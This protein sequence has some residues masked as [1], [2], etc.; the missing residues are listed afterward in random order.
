[1][2][3]VQ[4]LAAYL[5]D[6]ITAMPN[7]ATVGTIGTGVW[8]GTAI[9]SSYINAAQTGITSLGTQAADFKVGD[10]YGLV[11][12]HTAL[13]TVGIIPELQV[14]G[15]SDADSAI[16]AGRF[17][18]DTGSPAFTFLKSRDPA[19]AD[20][21][22]A[23]VEDGD[24][25]GTIIWRV[26][27]GTDFNSSAARIEVR[28]EG[29]PDTDDMPGRLAFFTTAGGA[30]NRRAENVHPVAEAGAANHDHDPG[31]AIT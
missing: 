6:E 13:A 16:M 19:V 30:F 22:F 7:L 9:T 18:A 24:S 25:L 3:T 12:G 2:T 1:M 29:T 11:V 4:T 10:G 8:Q 23:K 31:P 28:V 5:D 27:D 14:L 26:D 21:T 15:T 20:G 17:S